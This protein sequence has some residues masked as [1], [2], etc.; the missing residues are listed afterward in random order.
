MTEDHWC[1][2]HVERGVHRRGRRVGEVDQHAET[3]HLGDHRPAEVGEPMRS[4]VVG[5]LTNN[6]LG[7]AN[8]VGS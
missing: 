4:G 1:S 3:V 5:F 8:P 2:R 6:Y 7:W